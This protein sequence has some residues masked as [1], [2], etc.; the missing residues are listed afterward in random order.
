MA[1]ELLFEMR[2]HVAYLTMNRPEIHNALNVALNQA[3]A[4]A[5]EEV[6]QSDDIWVAVGTGRSAGT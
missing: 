1:D 3:L 4:D 6:R 2:G 5:W